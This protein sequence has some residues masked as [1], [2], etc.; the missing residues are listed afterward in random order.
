MEDERSRYVRKIN[1]L[2]SVNSDFLNEIKLLIRVHP[3]SKVFGA[4]TAFVSELGKFNNNFY[5]HVRVLRIAL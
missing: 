3:R 5:K 2:A 1:I 4:D